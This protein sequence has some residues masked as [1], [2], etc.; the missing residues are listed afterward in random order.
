MSRVCVLSV[1]RL[2]RQAR[3][4][5]QTA[6]SNARSPARVGTGL[7]PSPP[8]LRFQSMS[9]GLP[10]KPEA[11]AARSVRQDS[12]GN[13]IL[14]TQGGSARRLRFLFLK[15]GSSVVARLLMI[16]DGLTHPGIGL[17]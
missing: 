2:T 8:R 7:R 1:V 13:R 16:A 11:P 17:P 12:P 6:K 4:G 3:R 15:T 14:H 9:G 5:R 10:E